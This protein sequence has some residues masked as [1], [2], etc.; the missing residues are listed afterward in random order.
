MSFNRIRL[1]KDATFK[2]RSVAGRL[3][4]TPNIVYRLGLCLSIEEPSIPNPAQYDDL[5]QEI[6]RYTLFGE[7]DPL[8]I[9]LVKQR[10]VHDG[11]DFTPNLEPYLK[12]HLNRGVS[13]LS[14]RARDLADLYELIS[15][16]SNGEDSNPSAHSQEK[17]TIETGG[18]TYE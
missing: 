9:A 1:S 6:N 2:G 7:Y 4:I 5:G 17:R 12:A 3:G 13:L 18:P 11:F 10:L 14:N 8:F 16:T 15:S